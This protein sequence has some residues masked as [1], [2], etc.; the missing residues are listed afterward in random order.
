MTKI[1]AISASLRSKSLNSQVLNIAAKALE[2]A[3]A[4]VE[5][6]D[7]KALA[8]PIYDGD[9]EA[10]Q[11]VPKAAQSLKEK[12][13]A[14]DGVIIASPEHNSTYPAV[15]KNIIDWVSRPAKGEPMLAAFNAKPVALL[16]ASPGGLGGLRGLTN[17]R[18]LLGAI[19]MIVVP[20]Q[21]CVGG[22][23]ADSFDDAGN[24]SDAKQQLAVENV[25]KVLLGVAKKL[26]AK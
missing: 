15:L 24:L 9:Y 1:I 17:L 2:A 22:V 8:L 13:I 7:L 18:A 23:N 14:S 11:G 20:E 16:S 25:A 5:T 4:E 12:F 21:F 19:K 26:S 3:G 10:D 6:I